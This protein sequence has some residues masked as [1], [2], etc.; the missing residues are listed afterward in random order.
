M[1]SNFRVF[2]ISFH[3]NSRQAKSPR[4]SRKNENTKK[5]SLLRDS[6]LTPHRTR[7]HP[8]GKHRAQTDQPAPQVGC[9]GDPFSIES[10]LSKN[11]IVVVHRRAETA[12]RVD[13]RERKVD[14]IKKRNRHPDLS[15]CRA[16]QTTLSP[17][18][19]RLTP[20]HRL[21]NTFTRQIYYTTTSRTSIETHRFQ[22]TG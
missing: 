22:K 14:Q 18:G 13:R 5:C 3:F 6:L 12:Q 7:P 20:T 9:G 17:T 16:R 21:R 8:A 11:K 10:E 2:V 19:I 1:F 4:G 15:P